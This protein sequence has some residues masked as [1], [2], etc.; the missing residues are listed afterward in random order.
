MSNRHASRVEPDL[1]EVQ[2][3]AE[4]LVATRAAGIRRRQNTAFLEARRVAQIRIEG[5][6]ARS[7]AILVC[8][9]GLRIAYQALEQAMQ[10]VGARIMQAELERAELEAAIAAIDEARRRTQ[11]TQ[12]PTEAA[13]EPAGAPDPAPRT[14]DDGLGLAA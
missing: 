2:Y 1:R 6:E 4:R 7:H 11:E 10:R 12:R 5:A 3:Q 13:A 8:A 9:D 14:D